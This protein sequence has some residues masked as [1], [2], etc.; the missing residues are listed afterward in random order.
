MSSEKSESQK[1]GA[2]LGEDDMEID[3]GLKEGE[4]VVKKLQEMGNDTMKKDTISRQDL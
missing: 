2:K 3:S 4:K 1:K